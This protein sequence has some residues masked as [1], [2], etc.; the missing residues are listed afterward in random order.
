[1]LV[2]SIDVPSTTNVHLHE[3]LLAA[4]KTAPGV[5]SAALAWSAPLGTNTGWLVYFPDYVPKAD[6]PRTTPWVEGIS[7]G[8]FR[9]LGM[10]IVLGRDFDDRDLAT[11]AKVMIVNETFARHYF[12]SESPVGRHIGLAPGVFDVE[13]IGVARDGKYTGLREAPVRMM[14]VPYRQSIGGSQSTV[15]VRT[16]GEPLAFTPTLRRLVRA[17]DRQ[18]IVH[19]VATAQDRIDRTLLRERLVA[20][21]SGLFGGLALLLAA[22]GVYG[23]LSYGIAQR[24]REFGIRIAIGA[25]GRSILAMVLREAGWVLA[26]GIVGGL[27]VAWRLGRVIGSLLYGVQPGDLASLTIAVAVLAAAGTLAAWIPARRASRIDPMEA[28]RS[29]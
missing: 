3:R 8:Y 27:A 20:T 10:P 11:K 18:A 12:G 15:L 9:T 6:E 7:P 13:I 16:A 4:L 2:A 24:T 23:V 25:E 5:V 28:L 26:L 21:V 19:D 14:F 29:E 1:V 22:I 17:V